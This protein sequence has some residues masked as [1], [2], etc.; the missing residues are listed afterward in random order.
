M[1]N[2]VNKYELNWIE[3]QYWHSARQ[4]HQWNDLFPLEIFHSAKS[5]GPLY[6]NHLHT[7]IR[8]STI[9]NLP[10]AE[11]FAYLNFR[12]LV[13]AFY[14]LGH[15]LRERLEVLGT[16]NMGRCIKKYSDVLSL[17]IVP[18]ESFTWHELPAL[19][20]TPLVDINFLMFRRR[21]IHLWCPASYWLWRLGMVRRAFFIRMALWLGV[22]RALLFIKW[23]F[24][25]IA[26]GIR[27]PET[28]LI[29]TDSLSSI[30]A[31]LSRKFTHQTHPLVYKCKH[32]C[33]SLCQNGLLLFG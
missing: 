23:V 3:S 18:S 31:M 33:W 21:C 13:A 14:R 16:L 10:L 26:E 28:C 9:R 22:V 20:E 8:S 19:L 12:Y 2:F 27:P 32:L 7:H 1:N 17:D 15:P 24:L 6:H 11:R 25:H 29:L 4:A 30:K 5:S